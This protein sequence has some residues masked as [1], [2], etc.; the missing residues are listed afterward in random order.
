MFIINRRRLFRG[1]AVGFT[2]FWNIPY[3]YFRTTISEVLS[4]S[5]GIY[6]G[7]GMSVVWSGFYRFTG[8]FH[9]TL[10]VG[11]QQ[12]WESSDR[13]C[14]AYVC[15]YLCWRDWRSDQLQ[16]RIQVVLGVIVIQGTLQVFNVARLSPHRYS[17]GTLTMYRHYAFGERSDAGVD[18]VRRYF[19]FELHLRLIPMYFRTGYGSHT[20]WLWV[21]G[22]LCRFSF[23]FQRGRFSTNVTV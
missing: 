16:R 11:V 21:L 2:I 18:S 19:D 12:R 5:R 17:R 3:R 13:V 20:L 7:Q 9:P 22:P 8:W 23:P 6:P 14:L 10:H 4:S 1:E 15:S